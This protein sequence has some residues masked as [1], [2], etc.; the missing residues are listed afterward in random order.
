MTVWEY[1]KGFMEAYGNR[2]AFGGSNAITYRQLILLV[3]ARAEDI[4]GKNRLIPISAQSKQEQ[5]IELLSILASGCTAVSAGLSINEQA[6]ETENPAGS[7]RSES[8]ANSWT[9]EAPALIMPT[10]GTSG[11]KKGVMLS[12]KNII[13]NIEGIRDY[14]EV[15]PGERMLIVRPLTHASALTGELLAGLTLGVTFFF[16][17]GQFSPKRLISCIN[18]YKI[19]VLCSTPTVFYHMA[20]SIPDDSTDCSSLRTCVVSGERLAGHT[21]SVIQSRLKTVDFYHVY[22]LTEH[23]PRASA[24]TPS[25]FRSKPMSIGRPIK[26][27][28]FR[29]DDG[30]LLIKSDSVM[31]GYYQNPQLTEEKLKG[32]W[33]HTGDIAHTDA[34]GFYYIDGRTD[35]M[36]IRGGVNICPDDIEQ[37][38]LSLSG[39][40]GCIVYGEDDQAV[41]QRVC[42]DVEAD[43]AADISESDI[44]KHCIKHLESFMVPSRINL[45]DSLELTSSGK[46]KRRK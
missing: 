43:I 21:A 17:D 15:S 40:N 20:M 24:L 44:R 16:Y 32:G 36:I 8:C 9:G 33:L 46:V 38:I 35:A 10:S 3:E 12:H 31:L 18:K 7:C 23:S 42:A 37:V 22:G 45:V 6:N 29:I 25:E 19:Q 11:G 14:F 39:V 26:G 28:E 2:P 34:D 41:G 27:V 4:N 5:A 13:S 30:E 1:I